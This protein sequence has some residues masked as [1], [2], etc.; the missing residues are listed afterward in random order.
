MNQLG[1]QD[2]QEE[3]PNK[4]PRR[5]W[6]ASHLR[7]FDLRLSHW[8]QIVLTI[9]LVAL[10]V[11]QWVVYNRQAKI[12]SVQTNLSSQYNHFTAIS[13]RPFI[14]LSPGTSYFSTN[15]GRPNIN[16]LVN[17]KNDGNT[18]ATRAYKRFR[19]DKS[20]TDLAEPWA[21]MKAA[22]PAKIQTFIG[23]HDT[24]QGGCSF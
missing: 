15:N 23:P 16:F 4:P 8:V 7:F 22:A 21:F 18:A 19:C 9:G 3:T 10:A 20:E 11:A 1:G 24:S 14:S 13:Q 5:H 17:F 12:M 2:A 6:Y